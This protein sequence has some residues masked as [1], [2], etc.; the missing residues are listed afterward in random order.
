MLKNILLVNIAYPPHHY[1]GS[2][3]NIKNLTVFLQDLGYNVFVFTGG[4][5]EEI[6]NDSGVI[7]YRNKS[8]VQENSPLSNSNYL[9]KV[10]ERKFIN[11]I[12]KNNINIVHFNSI[13]GLGAN[14]IKLSLKLDIKTFLTMHDFWWICPS[15]F[16]K[17]SHSQ[18]VPFHNHE[19]F[20]YKGSYAERLLKRKQYL[21]EIL[22][23]NKLKIISVSESAKKALIYLG[24]PN[25]KNYLVV[26]NGII[27]CTFDKVNLTEKK[28]GKVVFSFLGGVDIS[29]KGFHLIY[30]A[31]SYLK[32]NTDKYE[33]RCYRVL[34]H[35]LK[36][37]FNYNS[38]RKRNIKL[39]GTFDN[40]KIY[41]I[42]SETDCLIVPS[43]AYET[44]SM[45]AREALFAEKILISSGMGALSEIP[46]PKHIIFNKNSSQDLAE[47][48]FDVI[49][50]IDSL[51]TRDS[52]LQIKTLSDQAKNLHILYQGN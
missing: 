25:A 33:I 40:S 48:M 8:H 20:C 34:D 52:G 11:I 14:L 4:R 36:T 5:R 42:L 32:L 24:L 18:T 43:Q 47:K 44:F 26:E 46:S 41:Q 21:Y 2:G 13:Q 15:L 1:G 3:I 19:Q 31:S 28:E 10:L 37:I 22:K 6:V 12:K 50:N 29:V 16:L 7:I 23:E 49:N 38:L 17:S 27:P 30:G 9:R 39:F 45:S 51:R 35:A